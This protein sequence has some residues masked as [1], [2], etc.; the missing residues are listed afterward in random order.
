M[1]Q[2]IMVDGCAIGNQSRRFGKFV[3]NCQGS[4]HLE[5]DAASHARAESR[6]LEIGNIRVLDQT[7]S[8]CVL[9]LLTA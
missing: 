9:Q 5:L 4:Q 8:R 1:Y 6:P 3:S 7:A 2:T